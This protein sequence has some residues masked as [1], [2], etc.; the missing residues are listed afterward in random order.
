MGWDSHVIKMGY[1]ISIRETEFDYSNIFNQRRERARVAPT[2]D[3]PLG[4]YCPQP[5]SLLWV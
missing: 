5:P 4:A 3:P 2:K 1:R